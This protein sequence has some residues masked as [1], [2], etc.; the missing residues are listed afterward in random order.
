[1]TKQK[2]YTR[3]IGL[4]RGKLRLW[5]EGTI[6][7]DNGFEHKAPWYIGTQQD[8]KLGLVVD[9][10]VDKKDGDRLIAGTPDRPIIDVNS[11]SVLEGFEAGDE[12]TVTVMQKGWLRVTK[13]R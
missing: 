1:M 5:L 12:V 8:S 9:L 11:G 3:K 7:K 2:T 13:A 4:N 6:L 10:V